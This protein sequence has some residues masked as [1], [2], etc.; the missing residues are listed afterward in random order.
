M[1]LNL[2]ALGA[3]LAEGD[4]FLGRKVDNNEAIDVSGFAVLQQTL[5]AVAQQRVV[6]AH[7]EDG[8]LEALAAGSLDDLEGRADGDAMAE[9]NLKP[10]SFVHVVSKY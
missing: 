3:E 5:L 7:D 10:I 4:G 2:P 1:W 6:V 9:G 8:S